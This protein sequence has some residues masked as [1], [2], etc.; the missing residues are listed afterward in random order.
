MK[1]FL[2]QGHGGNDPGA[3]GRNP[4]VAREDD[5]VVAVCVGVVL[6][7]ER[8]GHEVLVSRPAGRWDKR[9]QLKART[10]EANAWPADR[11]VSVHFNS[12]GKA[13]AHGLEFLHYGSAAG[14]ELATLMQDAFNQAKLFD[15]FKNRGLKERPGLAVLN[16]SN[17][18]AVLVELPFL[19]NESELRRSLDVSMLARFARAIARGATG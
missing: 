18:P 15:D 12:F 14:L 5:L 4:A 8:L 2:D 7:L 13:S 17:M 6:E 16:G 3:I 1:V 9:F 19:S 11:F 10:A